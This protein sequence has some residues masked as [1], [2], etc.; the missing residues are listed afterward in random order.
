MRPNI[1]IECLIPAPVLDRTLDAALISP[2]VATPFPNPNR[3]PDMRHGVH[4]LLAANIWGT[5][6]GALRVVRLG[7]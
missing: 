5:N 7:I 4:S 3:P 6:Y 1:A 2:G